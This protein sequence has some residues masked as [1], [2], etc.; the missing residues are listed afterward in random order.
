[1]YIITKSRG[2]SW[3]GE[4][5]FIGWSKQIFHLPHLRPL[6]SAWE[7]HYLQGGKKKSFWPAS[8]DHGNFQ[9]Q[10]FPTVSGNSACSNLKC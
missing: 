6:D 4:S 7:V 2:S 3:E 8:W 10:E 5:L 1:M 9:C